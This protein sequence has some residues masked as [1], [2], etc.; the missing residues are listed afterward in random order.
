MSKR[1]I[2]IVIDG[3]GVGELPDAASFGDSGANTL[4]NLS[5][6]FEGGISLPEL[7]R[8]GLGNITDIKG[9]LPALKPRGRWGK[10][11]QESAGK[12][13][14]TGHREMMGIIMDPP[15]PVYPDAFPLKV[16]ET[17]EAAIGRKVIGNVVDDG[18]KVIDKFGEEHLL[19]GSPIIYT[20][21]DSVC[22]IAVHEEVI[23]T[24]I[25]YDY[26]RAIREALT[27]EHEIGRVIARPFR[28]VVG[29][30]I[31]TEG[32]KDF[33]LRLPEDNVLSRLQN[34]DIPTVGIG[35]IPEMFA[36]QNLTRRI[37][38]VGNEQIILTTLLQMNEI[39]EGLIFANLTEADNLT[40]SSKSPEK[41][42]QS[43]EIIDKFVPHLL[44]ALR[45]DDLLLITS[46]HGF[47]PTV[48]G[49]GHN[50]TR[51]YTP[52]L[53]VQKHQPGIDENSKDDSGDLGIRES[54]ADIGQTVLE[55]FHVSGAGLSGKSFLS[56]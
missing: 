49:P 50:H 9:C 55:F 24:G 23:P 29:N 35:K 11:A 17:I 2:L 39:S 56:K 32:R 25:L 53:V 31:R 37:G 19:T 26:C 47:D 14:I 3:L 30:F 40:M 18:Q 21:D 1:V 6:S 36:N 20:S 41:F 46:D 42:K 43:L 44:N 16:V 15:L 8:L 28:G 12:G 54:F 5:F 22:Q 10:C 52:L 45:N 4:T 27:G 34:N 33:A 13:S 48:V 51:E 38:A 7:G